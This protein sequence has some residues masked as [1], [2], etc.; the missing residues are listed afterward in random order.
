M[1]RFNGIDHFDM[2]CNLCVLQTRVL[3]LKPD[4]ALILR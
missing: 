3:I 4:F 2:R 1:Y